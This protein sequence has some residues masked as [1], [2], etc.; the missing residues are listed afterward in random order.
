[1][2][3]ICVSLAVPAGIF[4]PS[5]VIG[6]CGGRIV[7]EIMAMSFPDGIRGRDGPQV[8]PGLYA[9]VG[10]F[11]NLSNFRAFRCRILTVV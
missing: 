5:F 10:L 9:V 4:V 6:A 7:G 2:V 8:F 11:E 1:M 3:A